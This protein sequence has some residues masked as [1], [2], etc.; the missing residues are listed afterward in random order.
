MS[1][2]HS[3]LGRWRASGV[4]ILSGIF[5]VA[6]GLTGPVSGASPAPAGDG[7][8][9]LVAA[10]GDLG[11]YLTGDGGMTLYYFAKDTRPGVSVCEGKCAEAWPPLL[12][13]DGESV[14]AGDGVSGVVASFTRPDG[15]TQVSYDG[16]P[17]YYFAG[18]QA[19]GDVT[20]QDVGEV[21]FVAAVDGSMPPAPVY[22][23]AAA[24]T[25]AGTVLTGEDGM[26]LYFFAN[27][28]AP[29]VSTCTGDC[30]TNWPPMRNGGRDVF[31]AGDGVTGVLAL[32]VGE[33]GSEQLTYDGRP[34]YYFAGDQ[35]AG[36]AT[37]QGIGGVWFAA[38]LDGS[39]PTP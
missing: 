25:A 2:S 20:G 38:T 37:G 10:N 18:D 5:V 7:T 36:D 29:G 3:P 1:H 24:T 22:T 11:T 21:W 27:D 6:A 8:H 28:T 26:T 32:A 30:L 33:D 19:A 14:S 15:S 35:A 31:V 13:G 17:L 23:I 9:T 12:L 16:R 34:L 4:A 39:M